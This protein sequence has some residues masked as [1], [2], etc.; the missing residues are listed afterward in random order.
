MRLHDIIGVANR[1][2]DKIGVIPIV[3]MAITGFSLVLRLQ[4][5]LGCDSREA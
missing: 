2:T 5:S 4:L 3:S 1:L